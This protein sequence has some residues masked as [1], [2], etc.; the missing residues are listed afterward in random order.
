MRLVAK[1]PGCST[2]LI[3]ILFLAMAAL[4]FLARDE[5][6]DF[7]DAGRGFDPR[8]TTMAGKDIAVYRHLQLASC[9]KEISKQP[10]ECRPRLGALVHSFLS[11]TAIVI[12]M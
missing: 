8:G 7:S 5:Y 2:I 6:P 9:N 12:I 1:A 4:G 3:A 11:N 10:D